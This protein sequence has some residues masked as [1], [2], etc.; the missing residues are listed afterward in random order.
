MT[1]FLPKD[2]DD[3][4]IPALRLKSGGAHSIAATAASARNS[5]AFS[6]ETRVV[7][8]YATG[9]VFVKFGG[10]TVTATASDHYFPSG[11]YYDIALGGGK[12]PHYTH[13]AVLRATA[14]CT[15]YISEKE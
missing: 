8:L 3:N 15:L 7:S 2:S 10:P 9:G 12:A 14:D 4:A 6:D 1:T 5:T 13:I 11:V